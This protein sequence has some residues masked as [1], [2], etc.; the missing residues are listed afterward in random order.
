MSKSVKRAKKSKTVNSKYFCF[1]HNNYSDASFE[2]LKFLFETKKFGYI[3]Y[4]REVGESGTPHL[5]GYL[6]MKVATRMSTL[7]TLMGKGYHI[8][9]RRG[10]QEEAHK[11]CRKGKQT[12]DNWYA[13]HPVTGES[14]RWT[15]PTYGLEAIVTEM[16]TLTVTMKPGTRTDI[17]LI[18]DTVNKGGMRALFDAQVLTVSQIQMAEKYLSNCEKPRD[19][20][21]KFYFITGK[22]GFGKTTLAYEQAKLM[23]YKD[24]DIYTKSEGSKWWQGYDAHKV[25]ILDDFRDS[26][27]PLT[28]FLSL[29]SSKPKT[30]EVKGGSRQ[31]KPEVIFVTTI[32][33]PRDLYANCSGDPQIQ[34]LRRIDRVTMLTKPTYD[35]S[36]SIINR[37]DNNMAYD[38]IND[39]S[40]GDRRVL[41]FNPHSLTNDK[42]DTLV[43]LVSPTW[44][45]RP[46]RP[47]GSSPIDIP[48]SKPNV[49]ANV[50]TLNFS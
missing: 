19:M 49:S 8:E 17:R 14:Y 38:S 26:W 18:K 13:I 4:G 43:P 45:I 5:Q 12:K 16:G 32:K 27:M 29:F 3:I 37:R 6:E 2:H 42:L 28:E 24:E 40:K 48:E 31:F 46:L 1:T 47:V 35:V 10:T 15:H 9:P 30:V 33:S 23:F 11:Y 7:I 20:A 21:P 36:V 25:V 22:S 50:Y 44:P 41:Q 34:I 39:E